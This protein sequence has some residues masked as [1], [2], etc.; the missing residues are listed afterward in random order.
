MKTLYDI[1]G[2][3]PEDDAEDLRV[4]FRKAV[5]AN[6]PDLNP[7]NPEAALTFRRIVRANAILSDERQREAYDRLLE[8]ARRQRRAPKRSAFSAGIRRL[9]IDAMASAVASVAFIA[10]YLLLKPVDR[11]PLASAQVTEISRSEPRQIAAA[12]STEL[13]SQERTDPGDKLEGV[14]ADANPQD[15][16]GPTRVASVSSA[17]TMGRAP[18]ASDVSPAGEPGPKDVKYYRERGGSAYRSGDL[19]IA[20]A[21]FDLAIQQDPACS[22]CYLDRG[23]VLYRMGDLKGAFSDVAEAKRIDALNRNKTRSEASAR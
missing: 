11:L 22:D 5:K 10:G 20:L 14:G 17:V 1:I 15:L 23:I 7:D 16:N 4:A 2:A 13:S 21:N 8:A 18:A 19:Y 6:H 3:L 12:R 9:G